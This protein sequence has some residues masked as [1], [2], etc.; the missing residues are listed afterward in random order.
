MKFNVCIK[1]YLNNQTKNKYT[2]DEDFKTRYF[3]LHFLYYKLSYYIKL[4]IYIYRLIPTS[5][6]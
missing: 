5:L 1:L 2:N 3:Q 4:T 6:V